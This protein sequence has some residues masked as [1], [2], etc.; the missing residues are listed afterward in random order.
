MQ[1]KLLTMSGSLYNDQAKEIQLRTPEG[2]MAILSGHEPFLAIVEPGP[3]TIINKD[4]SDELYSVFGGLVS[5]NENNEVKILVDE[6]DHHDNLIVEEIEQAI[7]LAKEL[8][9]AA[10]DRQSLYQAQ[11]LIDRHTVRLNVAKIRRRT[12]R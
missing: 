7:E 8:K 10:K 4:N 9:E 6:A 3:L 11:K 2:D 12:K 5:V 1:T